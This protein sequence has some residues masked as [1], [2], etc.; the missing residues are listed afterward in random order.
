MR[1]GRTPKVAKVFLALA[2]FYAVSPIDLIPVIIPII[3][4]LDDIIIVPGLIILALRFVPK[5]VVADCRL[6]AGA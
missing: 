3:G 6:R 1:D 4:F 2:I 5:D